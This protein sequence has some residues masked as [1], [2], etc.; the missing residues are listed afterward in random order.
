MKNAQ[1][2]L[3]F[4]EIHLCIVVIIIVLALYVEATGDVGIVGG[5]C[6]LLL[7]ALLRLGDDLNV[8]LL[9]L[10]ILFAVVLRAAEGLWLVA[11]LVVLVMIVVAYNRAAISI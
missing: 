11:A 2:P 8:L 5:Q 9:A 4:F 7:L 6:V 3:C 1:L 10:V